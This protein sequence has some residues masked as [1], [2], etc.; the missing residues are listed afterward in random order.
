MGPVKGLRREFGVL[1]VKTRHVF[2]RFPDFIAGLL[3][4]LKASYFLILHSL[5]SNGQAVGSAHFSLRV[6]ESHTFQRA[7][8]LKNDGVVFEMMF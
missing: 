2:C 8:V 6:V 7:Y 4:S 3:T 5:D 1:C